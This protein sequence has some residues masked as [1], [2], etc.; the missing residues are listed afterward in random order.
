[1]D[2]NRQVLRMTL[3]VVSVAV[4]LRLAAIVTGVFMVGCLSGLLIS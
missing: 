1:M 3:L 2:S 4:W